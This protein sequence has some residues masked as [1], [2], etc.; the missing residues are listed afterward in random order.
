MDVNLKYGTGDRDTL[1]ILDT[2]SRKIR[3]HELAEAAHLKT[4]ASDDL[5]PDEEFREGPKLL[6]IMAGRI[7][8]VQMLEAI[9]EVIPRL[10]GHK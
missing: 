10:K 4:M 9:G 1:I 8:I 7:S 2:M 6:E 5:D 3:E